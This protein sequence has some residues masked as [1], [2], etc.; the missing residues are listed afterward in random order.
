MP[1]LATLP[2]GTKVFVD[3]MIFDFHFRGKSVECARLINRIATGD[4]EAYVN[5]HVLS[6]LLHKLMLADAVTQL[7][8]KGAKQLKKHLSTH[9]TDAAQLTSYHGQFLAVLQLGIK[10][11]QVT[12]KLMKDSKVHRDSCGLMVTD[13]FHYGCMCRANVALTNLV[14]HDQD[15]NN[16]PGLTVWK[17]LDVLP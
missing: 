4:I 9:P 7:N 14:T 3:T 5:T 8:K 17:P 13:S 2:S 1:D 16:V 12:E 10:R 6:E 11:L 15:F